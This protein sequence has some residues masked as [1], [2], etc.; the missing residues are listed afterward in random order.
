MSHKVKNH[1]R[2]AMPVLSEEQFQAIGRLFSMLA[3]PTRLKILRNLESGPR[4]VSE[5][6]AELATTQAN[7]SKHLRLLHDARLLRRK[8]QGSFV[9]YEIADDVVFALCGIV[10]QKLARDGRAHPWAHGVRG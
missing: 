3:E 9:R 8:R 6:V 2:N 10:C 1:S 4:T 7:I 5:I